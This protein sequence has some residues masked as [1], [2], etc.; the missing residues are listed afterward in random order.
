MNFSLIHPLLFT[1]TI[2]ILMIPYELLKGLEKEKYL[3][4]HQPIRECVEKGKNR[5]KSSYLCFLL[6]DKILFPF[7]RVS[8]VFFGAES[9]RAG[10]DSNKH[11][12]ILWIIL[13]I[14]NLI[15]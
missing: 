14:C 15:D 11:S 13:K 3:Q 8:D 12:R 4:N 6:Q 7:R 9:E 5:R 10:F 2:S 1:E